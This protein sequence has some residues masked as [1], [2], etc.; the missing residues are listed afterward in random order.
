MDFELSQEQI[1]LRDSVVRFV[2]D[3]YDFAQ[4]KALAQTVLGHSDENWKIFAEMGWLA[5]PFAEENGGLGGQA[6]DVAVLTEALGSG[7]T[8]EPLF[9]SAL[10]GG[11][12][13]ETLG[14]DT[15][16]SAI[17]PSVLAGE[18]K[19]ALAY[20]E[21][22]A[23]FVLTY[24]ET[25]AERSGEGFVL[26]GRKSVVLQA[27]SA[28]RIIVVARTSGGVADA[29][30]LSA[31]VVDAEASGLRRQDYPTVDGQRASDLWLENTPGELLGAEGC[32]AP[33]L[34]AV[35]DAATCAV[36]AEAVGV[37]QAVLDITKEYVSTRKQ[38]GR[39]IGDNQVVQHR[40][41]DMS[42]A[43]E[44]AKAITEMTAMQLDEGVPDI[45]AQI[46]AMK[47][48]VGDAARFV[49]GQGLQLHGGIGMTDEYPVG[50]YYKRLMAIEAM[51]G[52]T[53]HHLNHFASAI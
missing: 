4:R 34:N 15:Q 39:A 26:N 20:S 44:E 41:V 18:T 22:N 32:A 38:Y 47:V 24:V 19:L 30:G 27:A 29:K 12:M 8:L 46:S 2:Q 11:R 16:K 48:K 52:D 40:L 42:I 53:N 45:S 51:F 28:D 23:R 37:M 33:A 14:S 21:P 43:L 10:L 36:C 9:S 50:H 7:I 1:M 25:T 13:V 5:L 3:H 35:I 6:V 17:I 31:F 49:G